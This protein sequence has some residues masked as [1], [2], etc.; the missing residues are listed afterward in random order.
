MNQSMKVSFVF[1][2]FEIHS[3]KTELGRSRLAGE[4]ARVCVY[5]WD[6]SLQNLSGIRRAE[7][8]EAVAL[9]KNGRFDESGWQSRAFLKFVCRF[10][11]EE[12][13]ETRIIM[14]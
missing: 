5:R 7:E 3:T 14:M 12:F 1:G 4:R 13:E 2:V 10:A 11:R 8:D 6:D 9:E